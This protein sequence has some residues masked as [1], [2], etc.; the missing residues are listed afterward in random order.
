MENFR[1]K[2]EL[3]FLPPYSP[4][5]S[6]IEQL[7]HLLKEEVVY[8]TF[9]PTVNDFKGALIRALKRMRE[10][11]GTIKKLYNFE[12]YVKAESYL[13]SRKGIYSK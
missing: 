9:Y 11:N 13:I 12:K 3:I 1:D 10:S 7:W 8:N 6:K 2:H 5:L 4:D